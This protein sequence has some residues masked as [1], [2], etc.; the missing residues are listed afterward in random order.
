M[1]AL[2]CNAK[3][4]LF[5]LVLWLGPYG[6]LNFI[7]IIVLFCVDSIH[8]YSTVYSFFHFEYLFYI[9]LVNIE[10]QG[11]VPALKEVK[12]LWERQAYKQIITA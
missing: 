11:M 1:A 10:M 2:K 3:T 7:C 8:L 5:S 12:G 6:F 9:S 4:V